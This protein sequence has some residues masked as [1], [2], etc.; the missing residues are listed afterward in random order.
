MIAGQGV[1]QGGV[2]GESTEPCPVM[3]QSVVALV[4]SRNHDRDHLSLH[5]PKR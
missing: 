3:G 2:F 5:A 4:G 1:N